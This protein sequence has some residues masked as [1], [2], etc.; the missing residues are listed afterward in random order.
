MRRFRRS[1]LENMA[2]QE[3]YVMA[4]RK[5]V[6]VSQ[7]TQSALV[8]WI[9]RGQA[10]CDLMHL[11]VQGSHQDFSSKGQNI[12]ILIYIFH[13]ISITIEKVQN[14]VMV[15]M[16]IRKE[17]LQMDEAKVKLIA[18]MNWIEIETRFVFFPIPSHFIICGS[19]E[20]EFCCY[21]PLDGNPHDRGYLLKV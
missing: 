8:I 19:Q 1:K 21:G 15:N 20:V 13:L 17:N 2:D 3:R 10:K 6:A 11:V 12:C 14:E 16:L 18:C 5:L 9:A 7:A 4:K